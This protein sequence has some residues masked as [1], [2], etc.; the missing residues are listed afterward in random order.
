MNGSA[1]SA[2]R[3]AWL[4]VFGVMA[5]VLVLAGAVT[6]AAA[7]DAP[8][9]LRMHA[10]AP[11]AAS[12]VLWS[13]LTVMGVGWAALILVLAADRG[14]GDIAALL[15][16]AFV[17]GSALTHVPK[18][19][20]SSPRPAG[21]SLLPHLHVIGQVFRGPVS[22]PSGHALTAAATAALLC[23]ALP[24]DRELPGALSLLFMAAL[25]GWSRV[26]VGAHWPSDVLVGAGL[27][28]LAT[29]IA[30]LL[31][32]AQGTGAGHERLVQGIRSRTGQGLVTLVEV[33]AAVGILTERTGYPAGRA[34][35]A[36]LA[37]VAV[38]SA[39]WRWYAAKDLHRASGPATESR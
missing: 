25:V 5:I 39:A 28:F 13:C 31:S 17:L 10:Q 21:T 23:L 26:V 18:Y 35:V 34:M 14:R 36:V 12:M 9:M 3:R 2:T 1:Y 16:V 4:T 38:L 6:R 37:G 24:R 19:I 8:W 33:A 32:R 11:D 20:L 22:M 30:L 29:G 27:G 15:A 7:L